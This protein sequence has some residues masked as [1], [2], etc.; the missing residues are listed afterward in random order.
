VFIS[1]TLSFFI[2]L[3]S[4]VARVSRYARYDGIGEISPIPPSAQ[5]Q[6]VSFF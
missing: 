2:V 1:E 3:S 4:N 5:Y 6:C